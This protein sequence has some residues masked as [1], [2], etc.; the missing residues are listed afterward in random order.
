MTKI[1]YDYRIK[2]L[3]QFDNSKLNSPSRD[4][5]TALFSELIWAGEDDEGWCVFKRNPFN[6]MVIRIDFYPPQ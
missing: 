1:Q 4:K 2:C 5:R 6:R 3:E